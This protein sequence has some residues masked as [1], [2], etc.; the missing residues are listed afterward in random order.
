MKPL[1]GILCIHRL[2]E[3]VADAEKNRG[4]IKEADKFEHMAHQ[5]EQSDAFSVASFH[6]VID[7]PKINLRTSAGVVCH[8]E[9]EGTDAQPTKTIFRCPQSRPKNLS[10]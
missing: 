6:S 9:G 1:K 8:S 10:C 5:R 4:H 2:F 3:T 7:R